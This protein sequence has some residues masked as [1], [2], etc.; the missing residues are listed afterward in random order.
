MSLSLKQMFLQS[1]CGWESGNYEE[2]VEGSVCSAMR[3][4]TQSA[5]YE[6]NH[7]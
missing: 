7:Q 5:I 2:G 6:H 3:S 1:L 4:L